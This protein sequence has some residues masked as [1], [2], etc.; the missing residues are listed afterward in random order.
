MM[1]RGFLGCMALL[2]LLLPSCK[3]EMNDTGLDI[4]P[5]YLKGEPISKDFHLTLKSVP[6][7]TEEGSNSIYVSS[8]RGYLGRMYN[9]TFGGV[10]SEY[11]TQFYIPEGFH[12]A[13]EEVIEKIDSVKLYIYYD[14]FAGDTI[15]NMSVTAHRVA[16]PLQH[17]KYSVTDVEEYKGEVLGSTSYWA[18]RGSSV[19]K[20]ANNQWPKYV[21]ITLPVELGEQFLA[22][23]K[24]RAPQFASQATFDEWF[25]GVYLRTS[26]GLGSVLR[27][28]STELAF[29]YTKEV[30]VEDPK[31]HKKEKKPRAFAQRLIHTSEV[32]QLSYFRNYRNDELLAEE[33]YAIMK[34]PAGMWVKAT[35]PTRA[36][37]EELYEKKKGYSRTLNAVTYTLQGETDAVDLKYNT[38]NTLLMLPVD[39]TQVFFEQERTEGVPEAVYTS[40]LGEKLVPASNTYHFGNIG[41]AIEKHIKANPHKD[42]DVYIIPVERLVGPEEMGAQTISISHLVPPSALKIA[43]KPE[44]T[45]LEATII[46]RREGKP[47]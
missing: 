9:E 20:G 46:E 2:L 7:G 14:G 32:P 29:W 38:P 21:A 19:N 34:A 39:S 26:A 31:T 35:I 47:F 12:F 36:I 5:E 37:A 43:I 10:E 3:G 28:S 18:G 27:V 24:A 40:F 44:N 22:L 15:A 16:K 23:S 41:S 30:E 42:L 33:G 13:D 17:S 1:N 4:L 25:S 6:A 45:K 11:L 8:S